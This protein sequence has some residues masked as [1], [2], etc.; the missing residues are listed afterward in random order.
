MA[1][2]LAAK[3]GCQNV[4]VTRGG[5]LSADAECTFGPDPQNPPLAGEAME[6]H[7]RINVYGSRPE[8]DAALARL[9]G[10]A[11]FRGAQGDNWII[12]CDEDPEVEQR[13]V[14]LTGGQQLNA[15]G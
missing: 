14:K 3:I 10:F 5:P 15:I 7:A 9:N 13:V 12:T 4:P 11:R 8:R 2:Q 1:K 6:F